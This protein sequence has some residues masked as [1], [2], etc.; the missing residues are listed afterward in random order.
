MG[1]KSGG[2]KPYEFPP[3][4]HHV[5]PSAKYPKCPG[6]EYSISCSR[7]CTSV[8]GKDY[9]SDKTKG[10]G[11]FSVRSASSIRSALASTGPLSVAFTVYQDFV[12]YKSGV[13]THKSGSA[14][15]GHAVEMIGYGNEDGTD[16]WLV[17]NSW[18]EQWGDGGCFKIKAGVNECGIENDVTGMKF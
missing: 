14:L 8:S 16:Y 1:E 3:C 17:K 4:A 11:A 15:G 2:C 9:N 10:S 6:S 7:S 5:P 12:T 18:N 13:Y